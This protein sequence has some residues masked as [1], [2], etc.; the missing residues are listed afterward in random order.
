MTNA[1]KFEEVF[2]FKAN[3]KIC[4][5][6]ED[7]GCP[8]YDSCD[9]CPYNKWLEEEYTGIS[10]AETEGSEKNGKKKM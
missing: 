5:L 6:P 8:L 3:N 1:E 10:P 7:I 2:G 4:F 9:S